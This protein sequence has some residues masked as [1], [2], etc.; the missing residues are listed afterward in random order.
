VTN[1]EI[2]KVCASVWAV[3]HNA[4]QNKR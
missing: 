1:R 2:N 4:K 3:I